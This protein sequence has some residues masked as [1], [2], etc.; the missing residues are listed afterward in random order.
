MFECLQGAFQVFQGL[1]V[2]T[3]LFQDHGDVVPDLRD[4]RMIVADQCF[5]L[6][7]RLEVQFFRLVIIAFLSM[8][9]CAKA[10][11]NIDSNP[12]RNGI[13]RPD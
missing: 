1:L 5:G 4:G 12:I 3:F 2:L 9:I 7:E 13:Y 11:Q 6:F 10:K 8:D